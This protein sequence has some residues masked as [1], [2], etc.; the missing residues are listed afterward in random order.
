MRKGISYSYISHEFLEKNHFTQEEYKKAYD[1]WVNLFL[2]NIDNCPW[3]FIIRPDT[4]K[5]FYNVKFRSKKGS[6]NVRKIAESLEGGG[7]DYA[8][9]GTV[10]A[11]TIE[12][13]I[14]KILEK[15]L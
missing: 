3:G 10:Q 1:S 4:K 9:A 14:E 8:A 13:V 2:R 6:K 7:H 12:E 11:K 5:G 15:T